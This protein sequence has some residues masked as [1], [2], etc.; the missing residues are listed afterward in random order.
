MKNSREI[1][2]A[3][4]KENFEDNE[5]KNVSTVT[6]EMEPKL[7]Y[8]I[9]DRYLVKVHSRR[10]LTKLISF[11]NSIFDVEIYVEL[12]YLNIGYTDAF[13]LGT[14]QDDINHPDKDLVMP[15]LSAGAGPLD[16]V[17]VV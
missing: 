10:S 4:I 13:V 1:I 12:G 14:L 3:F 16:K 11:V 2:W 5:L 17:G 6:R 15:A 7:R 9:I 8:S